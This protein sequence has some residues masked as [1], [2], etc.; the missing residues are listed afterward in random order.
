MKKLLVS[1]LIILV[2]LGGGIYLSNLG[3]DDDGLL[4]F[5]GAA[6]KPATEEIVELFQAETGV[7]VNVNFGGSGTVLSQM[8]LNQR[9]DIYFPGSSDYM[10]KAE[11]EGLV[12][13]DTI[14]YATYLVSAINVPKGNPK[15]IQSLEDLLEPGVEVGIANP[16]FVCVGTYAVEVIENSLN[17][18]EVEALRENIVYYADSCA[19]TANAAVLETVDAVIGWRVFEDWEPEK[20]E[21]IPLAKEQVLRFGYIPIAI[22]EFSENEEL[23]QEFIDFIQSESGQEVFR[24]YGYFMSVDEA[25]EWLG[26]ER[27]VGGE[28][29]VPE[30]WIQ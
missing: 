24:K 18:E 15:D 10:I 16:E 25:E 20:I 3:A 26:E 29:S 6:S 5:A 9:G 27:P 21:T 22:S 8:K 2:I 7:K 14:E 11:E 17:A 1:L 12:K 4:V 28:Y 13:P 19:S 30:E 23:A